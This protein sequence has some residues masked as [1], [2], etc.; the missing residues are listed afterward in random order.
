MWVLRHLLCKNLISRNLNSLTLFSGLLSP[1]GHLEP[2]AKRGSTPGHFRAAYY[3]DSLHHADELV[4][5]LGH[6]ISFVG[7]R[8]RSLK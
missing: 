6:H 3:L 5:R 4:E 8:L 1:N 7:V 2:H